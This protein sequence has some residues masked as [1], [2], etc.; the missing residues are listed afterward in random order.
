M[1][2]NGSFAMQLFG[3]GLCELLLLFERILDMR[4]AVAT[5]LGNLDDRSFSR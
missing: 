2:E 5:S 3:E 1:N 4:R